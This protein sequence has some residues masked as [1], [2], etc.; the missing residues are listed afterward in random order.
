MKPE[1]KASGPAGHHP[2]A[3]VHGGMLYSYGQPPIDPGTDE[4]KMGLIEDQADKAYML[5]YEI[6]IITL[7]ASPI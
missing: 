4:K 2:R 5:C 1:E 7:K 6:L 3:I